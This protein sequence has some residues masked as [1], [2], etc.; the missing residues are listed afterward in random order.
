[1][2]E[3]YSVLL[4]AVMLQADITLDFTFFGCLQLVYVCMYVWQVS[5]NRDMACVKTSAYT[6]QTQTQRKFRQTFIP[7]VEFELIIPLSEEEKTGH[8]LTYFFHSWVYHLL[9][10]SGMYSPHRERVWHQCNCHIG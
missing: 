1:M 6:E 5:I 3:D 4:R 8:T 2:P 7:W 9:D 10:F